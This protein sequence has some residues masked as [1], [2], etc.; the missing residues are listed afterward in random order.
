MPVDTDPA[1]DTYADLI[2]AIAIRQDRAAF[3]SL[4]DHFA[5]R[6]KGFLMRGNTS[7]GAAE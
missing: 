5:P 7:P 4:F 2:E 6:I 1:G 3:A